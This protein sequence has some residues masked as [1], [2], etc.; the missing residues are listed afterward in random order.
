V[1]RKSLPFVLVA[2][3]VTGLLG[4]F[5]YFAPLEPAS[6]TVYAGIVIALA[7]LVCVIKPLRLLGLR[8]RRAGVL[9]EVAGIAFALVGMSWPAGTTRIAERHSQLDDFLPEYQFSERHVVRIHASPDRVSAALKE[10]TFD[11]LRVYDTLMRIRAMASGRFRRGA[12]SFGG[13]PVLDAFRTPRSGFLP[14]HEDAREIVMGMAGRPWSNG[15]RPKIEDAAGFA[16]FNEPG[17]VKIAFNLL[18]EEEGAGWSRVVTETRIRATDDSARRTM[19]RYWR[20]IYPGSGMIRRMWLN[21]IRDRA[22]RL[23]AA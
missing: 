19:G 18:V 7:G 22:E 10:V 11:E 21:A 5:N 15:P 4:V 2:A 13:R 17:S 20:V 3:V 12:S 8:N 14:L 1:I 16:A 9:V 23:P 6:V